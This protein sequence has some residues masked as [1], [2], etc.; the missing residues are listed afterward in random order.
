M[1][2]ARVADLFD[3]TLRYLPDDGT[4]LVETYSG[5]TIGL[6]GDAPEGLTLRINTQSQLALAEEL[7]KAAALVVPRGRSEWAYLDCYGARF[8]RDRFNAAR[9]ADG[10]CLERGVFDV[11]R[12][13]RTPPE[14]EAAVFAPAGPLA[15]PPVEV[16]LRWSRYRPGAFVVNL[17]ADL[18]EQFGGR[19]NQARF[20]RAGET[21]EM[22]DGVVTEPPDDP[23][24]L[25]ARVNAGSTLVE[26]R[27]VQR[28]PIGFEAA[29]V[30][31]RKPR[32]RT[33]SGGT[34]GE[35]ARLYLA[36]KDVPGFI[37]LRARRP[38]AWGNAIAVSVRKV[39]PA[40]F[41]VTVGYQGARF[42]NARQVALVGRILKPGE[43][44]LPA[45]AEDLLAPGPAGVLQ[46]KAAGVHADVTRN[47]R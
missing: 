10:L 16:R 6:G 34:D 30:P 28:V 29:P 13:A 44:P 31:L 24:H 27:I 47:C 42:E 35:P 38:G 40:R 43:E 39:G 33:L 7:D 1:V 20:G 26:A 11:S 17:P 19:F 36:E 46:A 41:D 2:V 5:V 14:P 22:H 21:P 18:S 8:K 37:E 25:V 9:F 15:D 12:F 3:V 23:D 45:L 32:T 4:P